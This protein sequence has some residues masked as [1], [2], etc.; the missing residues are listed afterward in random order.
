MAN[1]FFI[2]IGG[3]GMSAIAQILA[4]RGHGVSGSDRSNDSGVNGP[5]FG[6]LRELGI[7]LFP[8]DG[9]G[10][11]A[12]CDCVVV[13]TAIEDTVPDMASARRLGVPVKHRAQALAELFNSERGV[14][15]GG[16]SGKST[17]CGMAGVLLAEA[18][19]DPSIINGGRMKNF[20]DGLLPGN[21]RAGRS[22][23]MVIESDE[24]DGSIVNY[25]PAVSIITNV[26]KDHK[27]IPE[28]IGLFETFISNTREL[29]VI[30]ADCPIASKL[31]TD[32][33]KTVYYALDAEADIRPADVELF[34]FSSTFALGGE[35]YV[36]NVPGRHNV[37]NA[38]AAIA[39]G[40]HLGIPEPELR[41]GIGA[42]AGIAR[43]FDLIGEAGGVRVIDDFGHNPDKIR[44]T[45]E[46]LGNLPGRRLLVF[47]PH[48][49]GPT[50]F[51]RDELIEVFAAKLRPEDRL[52]M[53][54]IFYAGGSAERSVSSAEIIDAVVS[55]GRQAFFFETRSGIGDALVADAQAGDAIVVM[56][57]RDDTLTEF[58]RSVLSGLKSK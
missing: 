21:A 28:L 22:D 56:G 5:F 45:I 16:T 27:T 51:M 1:Y 30:N 40:R 20:G 57:A 50:K 6:K 3:S 17:V 49:F 18:G 58:C 34:P 8:Q 36:L 39:V 37:S 14:A 38:L 12:D 32:G 15:A 11:T 46:A 47:Q 54:E 9:S 43:R 41:R 7:R 35:K 29:A 4:G 52:Y 33:R 25:Q 19:L 10:V 55:R 23:L 24:S 13:S 53:P 48:G 26:T 2:G 31:K 44:A 42:F